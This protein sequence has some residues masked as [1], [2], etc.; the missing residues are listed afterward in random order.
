M[1]L[2]DRKFLC[3]GAN[4]RHGYTLNMVGDIHTLGEWLDI[5]FPNKNARDYFDGDAEKSILEYLLAN[6]G[7]RL[8]RI[9]E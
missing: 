2:Y 6:T 5:L 9:K 4:E 3:R 1:K 8:E 7:K